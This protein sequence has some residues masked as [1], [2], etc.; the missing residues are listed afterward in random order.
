MYLKYLDESMGESIV[1][2]IG[3][4]T[5]HYTTNYGAVLQA[6]AVI[7]FLREIGYSVEII[8]SRPRNA[9][10]YYAKSLLY[11]KNFFSGLIKY[12]R[13]RRFITNELSLSKQ[14]VYSSQHLGRICCD[15]SVLVVGSDEVW[16]TNS[17]RGFDSGF[18]LDFAA[19]SQTRISFSASIGSQT[20]FDNYKIHVCDYLSKFYSV[21]VRDDHTSDVISKECQISSTRLLDPTWLVDVSRFPRKRKL[22]CDYV[23]VYGRFTESQMRIVKDEAVMLKCQVISVGY[24]NI[25]TDIN[26]LS[27]GVEDWVSLLEN[28][29]TVFTNFY[30]G[31]IF[32]L[33]FHN[34]VYFA[35]R[36]DKNY[37]VNQLI[38]DL[39]LHSEVIICSGT[40]QEGEIRKISYSTLTDDRIS[41]WYDNAVLFF[42]HGLWEHKT[43]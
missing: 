24:K 1:N 7:R 8:D 9:I 6:Y 15:Y 18:F 30:H 37:K 38:T 25:F 20:S 22:Y 2:K 26:L 32:G 34:E 12:F 39:C 4:L 3:V 29:K 10:R 28:A 36:A 13:F 5:Y 21:S 41:Q 33:K 11:N 16:K 42:M 27:V 43:G 17:F 14:K 23:L 31:V 40:N 19:E 35:S